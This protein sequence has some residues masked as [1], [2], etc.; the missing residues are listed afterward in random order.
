MKHPMKTA[1]FALAAAAI[2]SLASC[3]VL[4]DIVAKPTAR[5]DSVEIT[6][7][8]FSGVELTVNV[9]IDN[10]NPAGL[11]LDAYDYCLK[12]E[13]EDVVKGRR[14]DRVSMKA[15]G[16]SILPIPIE[17]RFDELTAVGASLL[18]DDIVPV[19]AVLGL[20]IAVP[21]I[22]SVRL[23][24]SG[25]ADIPVVRPPALLPLGI[26]VE[27]IGLSG[28]TIT[29]LTD[30][31]N[32]NAYGLAVRDLEGEL[33]VA[34]NRWGRVDAGGA[35]DVAPRGREQVAFRAVLD[36]GEIG[37]SAWN[38][39]TGSANLDVSLAGNMDVD[40]DLPEFEH[41]GFAWDADASVSIIR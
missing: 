31:R 36:F 1:F 39:L 26:R 35:I 4:G 6:G 10:P 9:E 37:R 38:L 32:P 29:V 22:G 23:D 27:S 41:G 2:L 21:Y 40:L 16:K 14:E 19:A 17:I 25:S 28:A 18:D 8:D 30:M 34:G 11:T 5:V 33:T 13:G 12:V 15:N 7:V 3:G 24:V 20:E